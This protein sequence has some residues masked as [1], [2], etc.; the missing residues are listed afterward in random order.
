MLRDNFTDQGEGGLI[1]RV[2]HEEGLDAAWISGVESSP[3][4]FFHFHIQALDG[5]NDAHRGIA[6]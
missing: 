6:L 3:S 5:T 2:Q 1:L 4:I